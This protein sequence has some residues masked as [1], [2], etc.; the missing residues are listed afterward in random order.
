MVKWPGHVSSLCA[1]RLSR[2]ML[3]RQIYHQSSDIIIVERLLMLNWR[4]SLQ[5]ENGRISL[6]SRS[7]RP[8]YSLGTDDSRRFRQIIE[9]ISIT[10]RNEEGIMVSND[11][12][13]HVLSIWRNQSRDVGDASNA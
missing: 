2:V 6:L 8:F 10:T 5:Y 3:C 12:E 13:I 1:C 11:L 9:D 4:A 7:W